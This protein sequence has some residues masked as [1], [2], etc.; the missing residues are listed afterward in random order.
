MTPEK[1]LLLCETVA[2]IAAD[3]KNCIQN[4]SDMSTV[5]TDHTKADSDNFDKI[6]A[7]LDVLVGE[8]NKRIGAAR[9]RASFWTAAQVV[10]GVG[11]W[12]IAKRLLGL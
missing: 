5:L 6:D 3:L 4:V 9:N 7:K 11:G 12:E 8:D 1:E 2:T 10:G